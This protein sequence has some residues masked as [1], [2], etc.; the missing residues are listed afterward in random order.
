MMLIESYKVHMHLCVQLSRILLLGQK[1][2]SMIM[3]QK[4]PKCWQQFPGR[5]TKLCLCIYSLFV[6]GYWTVALKQQAISI[7]TQKHKVECSNCIFLSPKGFKETD[8]TDSTLKKRAPNLTKFHQRQEGG[9]KE[10]KKKALLP[11]SMML[12][13]SI[14]EDDTTTY[15]KK[16]M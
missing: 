4:R 9:R 15:N 14:R 3:L 10:E 7:S 12:F 13:L 11:Q 8:P 5:K 6:T 16:G 2:T 1:A